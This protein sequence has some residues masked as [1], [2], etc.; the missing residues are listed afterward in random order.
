MVWKGTG[1]ATR[2]EKPR[3][4]WAFRRTISF[5]MESCITERR[6]DAIAKR[7]RAQDLRSDSLRPISRMGRASGNQKLRRRRYQKDRA[8]SVA[9]T[10][11]IGLLYYSGP[12]QGAA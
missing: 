9:P 6:N 2:Q 5:M 12:S 4:C 11:R 1:A 7:I 10:R 3:R 8:R